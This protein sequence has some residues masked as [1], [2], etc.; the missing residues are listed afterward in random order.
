M[1]GQAAQEAAQVSAHIP[2]LG[3]LRVRGHISRGSHTQE[4]AGGGAGNI[5]GI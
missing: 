1:K 3:L 4:G 5:G 2:V